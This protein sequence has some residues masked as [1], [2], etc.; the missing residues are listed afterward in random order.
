MEGYWRCGQ[1]ILREWKAKELIIFGSIG[2][3]SKSLTWKVISL[4]S[5]CQ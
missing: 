4:V 5:K 1:K 3:S 2:P